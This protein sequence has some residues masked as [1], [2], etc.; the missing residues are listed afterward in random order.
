MAEVETR[1][2]QLDMVVPDFTLPA[3]DGGQVS[4]RDYRQKANLVIA[5][6][7]LTQCEQCVGF[8]QELADNYH[9]YRDLDTEVLAVCPES[10]PELQA[11]IGHLGLPFPVLSDLGGQVGDVYLSRQP[12]ESP[13]AELFVTDRYGA[14]RTTMVACSGSELP[15]QQSILDWLSLIE[16]ECPEC[17]DEEPGQWPR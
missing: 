15:N 3:I 2:L 10:V 11:R 6:L 17:S 8:L 5:Y 12:C 7:K 9:I 4:P 16:S 1:Q 13:V 14:L